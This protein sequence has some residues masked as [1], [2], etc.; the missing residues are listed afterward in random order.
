M[1]VKDFV[2]KNNGSLQVDSEPGEGTEFRVFL[3]LN[4]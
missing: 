4:N 1:L 3:P 2:K